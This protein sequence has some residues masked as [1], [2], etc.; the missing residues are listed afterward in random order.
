MTDI[1]AIKQAIA[2]YCLLADAGNQTDWLALYTAD[3]VMSLNGETIRGREGIQAWMEG[4][5]RRP[6]RHFISNVWID[7]RGDSANSICYFMF[8]SGS[9]NQ[10]A[11]IGEYRCKFVKAPGGWK[12]AEWNIVHPG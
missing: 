5:P 6:G 11:A 1:E 3:A 8:V 9:G 7:L 2:A 4:R 10:I 12:I